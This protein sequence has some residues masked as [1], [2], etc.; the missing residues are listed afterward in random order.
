MSAFVTELSGK[1]IELMKEIVPSIS[2]VAFLAEHGK[3][4][5][6]AA[7]GDGEDGNGDPEQSSCLTFEANKTLC[8]RL[9]QPA[10]TK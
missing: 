5:F 10:K 1:R 3:S 8:E 2:N 7:M 9:L 6:S 4:H